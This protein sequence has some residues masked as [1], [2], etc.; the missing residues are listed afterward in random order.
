MSDK[1][2]VREDNLLWRVKLNSLENSIENHRCNSGYFTECH[3]G[4]LSELASIINPKYQTLAYHGIPKA[5]LIDFIT[6]DT[7]G[8]SISGTYW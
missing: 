7:L 2:C 1:P 6:L 3:A 4:S 8:V 5:D